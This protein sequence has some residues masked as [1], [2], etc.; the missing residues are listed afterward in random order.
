MFRGRCSYDY[1]SDYE[2]I[3]NHP[4][5]VD[6]KEHE[7]W[8]NLQAAKLQG[9]KVP[10]TYLAHFTRENVAEVIVTTG[11]FIGGVKK[12]NEDA[13]GY[14]LEAKFSWWSPKFGEDAI[15]LVRDTLREAIQPFLAPLYDQSDNKDVR[16]GGNQDGVIQP[17]QNQFATSDAFS[18]NDWRCGRAYF[19]YDINDLCQPVM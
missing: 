7:G 15:T 10:I 13:E 17:L 18:P 19:Q 1:I 14:D 4:I 12:I 6:V 5:D 11:G 9:T 2:C 3:F 8:E 16:E